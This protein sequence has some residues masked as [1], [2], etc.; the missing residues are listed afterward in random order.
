MLV[1]P[2]W[3]RAAVDFAAVLGAKIGFI[4]AAFFA[5]AD[6]IAATYSSVARRRV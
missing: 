4:A 6:F 3:H 1:D 2:C 5:A